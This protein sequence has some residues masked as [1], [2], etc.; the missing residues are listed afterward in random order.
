MATEERDQSNILLDYARHHG[1]AVDHTL[2]DIYDIEFFV[3]AHGNIENAL[4]DPDAAPAFPAFIDIQQEKLVIDGEARSLLAEVIRPVPSETPLLHL[5][6][7]DHLPNKSSVIGHRSLKSLKLDLPL[8]RTD[9]D[10]DVLT[11]KRKQQPT[12]FGKVKFE[13][14]PIDDEKDEGLQ[15]PQKYLDISK[16]YDEQ[17]RT[18]KLSMSRENALWL[19]DQLAPEDDSEAIQMLAN[20]ELKR[21]KVLE[22][23]TPP[24]SP[25]CYKSLLER[26]STSPVPDPYPQLSEHTSPTVH[27]QKEFDTALMDTDA[28]ILDMLQ[29][30]MHADDLTA[31]YSPL[32]SDQLPASSSPAR[33]R[34]ERLKL[35]QPLT[36]IATSRPTKAVSFVEQS[37]EIVPN[38][39]FV[40]NDDM[41]LN[42]SDADVNQLFQKTFGESS[43]RVTDQ[44]QSER[45]IEADSTMRLPMP[46][47][48]LDVPVLPWMYEDADAYREAEDAN[49][50][51]M[52]KK[53]KLHKISTGFERELPWNPLPSYAVMPAA[54][55]TTDY[56]ELVEDFIQSASIE[57]AVVHDNLSWKP[58]GLRFLDEHESDDEELETSSFPPHDHL[59][60]LLLKRKFETHHANEQTSILDSLPRA[61]V[62]IKT[63]KQ[64][65][66]G[67][68]SFSHSTGMIT[69]DPVKKQP[70]TAVTQ[71]EPDLFSASD[72]LSRFMDL[73]TGQVRKKR[74]M[75]CPPQGRPSTSEKLSAKTT[76]ATQHPSKPSNKEVA[77]PAI[78]V[79][80]PQEIK[81]DLPTPDTTT[82]RP[83]IVSSTFLT[84]HR[85]LT[86]HLKTLHPHLQL[87]ERDFA[88][89][90]HTGFSSASASA[91][92]TI[93]SSNAAADL[94]LSPRTCII[95]TTLQKAQQKPL[96]GQAS[97][98][99]LRKRIL[100]VSRTCERV[101]VLVT[102]PG[103]SV[104]DERDVRAI[105]ELICFTS[106]QT[107]SIETLVLAGLADRE[108]ARYVLGILAAEDAE[109]TAEE[110]VYDLIQEETTWE[111][112]LRRAG[113]NPFAAQMVL[114]TLK[115]PEE[116]A[117]GAERNGRDARD[118]VQMYG[119]PAFVQM[120]RD[121]RRVRFGVMMGGDRVLN[122]V[123]AALDGRWD[124][125]AM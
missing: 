17:C 63:T 72:E 33:L 65:L 112:F 78:A 115:E 118:E 117:D 18:E 55:D 81:L 85:P 23:L 4:R 121:E 125:E 47:H 28:P 41:L 11:C 95:F 25:V 73:Q 29:D 13:L 80:A 69:T 37:P 123:S 26:R 34:A 46:K 44:L 40:E 74:K 104:S 3:P 102:T 97:L 10:V 20:D 50:I 42:G 75:N 43:I 111:V 36:P 62:P 9:P 88:G 108:I 103:G 49:L 99:P 77:K 94:I 89:L 24:L 86:T 76:F 45:L 32:R 39:G 116:L 56:T 19:R 82:P 124:M 2:E 87:I 122:Q 109:R 38:L 15:W 5:D 48:K 110:R 92:K 96:P 67:P 31:L 21:R 30:N 79:E 93:S 114:V 113:L 1:L 119:L 51:S 91:G 52:I 64:Q 68:P 16:E 120:G 35:E 106:T 70:A 59:S 98:S 57:E 60:D 12:S 83:I 105:S 84:T 14:I 61:P 58:D 22:P 53:M 54:D 6:E 8:L 90:E 7:S 71:L 100:E 101:I 66:W 27:L 107:G